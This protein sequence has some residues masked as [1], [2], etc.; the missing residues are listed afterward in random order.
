MSALQLHENQGGMTAQATYNPAPRRS[1]AGWWIALV[2]IGVVAAGAFF[3]PAANEP[4][5]TYLTESAVSGDLEEVVEG[6]GT[7]AFPDEM[8]RTLTARV[9]G[10]VTEVHLGADSAIGALDPIVDIDDAT[11]WAVPGDAP[12]YRGLAVDAEGAD[13]ET[14]EQALADAGYEPG[15]VDE[16]FDADTQAALEA[17]QADN[18][19]EVTGVFDPTQFV[20]MPSES[21]ALDVPVVLGDFVQPGSPLALLGP[22]DGLILTVDVDQADTTSIEVGD[23]V[24]VEVDGIDETISGT[25]ESI[26]TL[27]SSGTDYEVIVSLDDTDELLLGMEGAA[28]IVTSVLRDVVLVPTGALGGSADAP[29]VNVLIDG[30]SVTRPV[31]TGLMTPTQVEITSGIA[32]GDAIILGEVTE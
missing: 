7:V 14:L 25:V 20:W 23:E 15:E 1:R 17:W 26:A 2:V 30:T 18:E 29:T 16:V 12:I 13:V 32:A 8:V 21:V 10:T 3:R 19:L 6:T 11:L 27:P 24:F 4:A 22:S 5:P 9:G 28:T 31:T